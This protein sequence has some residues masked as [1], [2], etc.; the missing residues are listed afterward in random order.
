MDISRT[1]YGE[2]LRGVRERMSRQ[3]LSALMVSDPSNLYY[4]TGYNAWSFYTP[5]V[6]FVPAVGDLLLFARSMDARGAFRTSWLPQENVFGYPDELVHR[7]HVH[8]FDWVSGKLRERG[9]VV[10]A[11][12]GQVGLE[13][14]SHFFSPKAYLSLVAALPEWA[15]VDSAELVNWVRAVKSP[16]EIELM[17]SAAQIATAAMT[18]AFEHVRVGSRQCDVAAEISRTQIHGTAEFGG[19]Y[20]AIVPMLP[21]GAEADT[22]H[23]TWTDARFVDGQAV[24]VELAGA[25]RRY[26]VPLARTVML[27]RPSQELQRVAGAVGEGIQAVLETVRPGIQARDLATAWDGVLA[28]YGL[29]KP[30]RIGYSIGIGYP[31]DWGER[32]VSLRAEDETVLQENMTFHLI[33]GMW[34]DNYGYELSEPMRVT[35][36]GVETFTSLPRELIQTGILS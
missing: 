9:V 32:T 1:E 18:T 5:Q 2:R 28:T 25:Y 36:T 4:L 30:S 3:G 34:M 10:P 16:A 19:D 35:A 33:G 22:P 15:F 29:A 31:P 14:D 6:L 23:L 27:G 26:H 12:G 21:T 20:P 11:A 17:R 8:P 24:I 7:A 13:L